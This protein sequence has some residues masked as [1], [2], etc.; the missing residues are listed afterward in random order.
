MHPKQPR[1]YGVFPNC[2]RKQASSGEKSRSGCRLCPAGFQTPLGTL[3]L[4]GGATL[5][6]RVCSPLP[7]R[8]PHGR[9]KVRSRPGTGR[10]LGL[11]LCC[12]VGDAH[13]DRGPANAQLVLKGPEVVSF[14]P[15]WLPS[16][17]G[18]PAPAPSSQQGLAVTSPSSPP[19]QQDAPAARPRPQPSPGASVRPGPWGHL[20]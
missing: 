15:T 9:R 18:H 7:M 12:N 10:R 14:L 3:A 8:R 20:P 11:L 2:F 17:A 19:R 6:C 5:L 13:L 1:F 16:A 4:T